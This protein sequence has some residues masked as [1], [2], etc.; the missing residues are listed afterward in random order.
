MKISKSAYQK[1]PLWPSVRLIQNAGYFMVYLS[2]IRAILWRN[3]YIETTLNHYLVRPL[4]FSS[5]IYFPF[6][7]KNLL[8]YI[9]I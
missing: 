4:T 9:K 3:V 2:R 6:K 8:S 5:N 7:A 1:Y